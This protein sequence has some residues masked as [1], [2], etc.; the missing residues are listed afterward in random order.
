MTQDNGLY[1]TQSNL[2]IASSGTTDSGDYYCKGTLRV[3]GLDQLVPVRVDGNIS[4][5]V[6]GEE[7]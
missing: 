3:D 2:T 5:M 4:L 1:Q 7:T 6:Q